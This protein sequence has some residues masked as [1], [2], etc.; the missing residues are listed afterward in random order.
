MNAAA[1]VARVLAEK[2]VADGKLAPLERPFRDDRRRQFV[3]GERK[4]PVR[5]L[6]ARARQSSS[7]L[8]P[9]ERHRR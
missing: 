4:V 6:E 9:T 1:M 7:Q 5:S 2:Q 8:G 3:I